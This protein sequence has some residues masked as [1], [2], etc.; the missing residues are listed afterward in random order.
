M[1]EILD[2]FTWIDFMAAGV[3][4]LLSIIMIWILIRV[5]K[6]KGRNNPYFYLGLFLLVFVWLYP[7]YTYLFNQLEVG[8]AGNLLTLWL[9]LK[10][11]SRLKEVK[12]NLHNYLAPQIIWLVLATLYVGLQILVK[13]QS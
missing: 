6:L 3:W 13:Y 10:Y 7:L 1:K 2:Y 4:I 8:A 11:R 9:T 5:D 12:Q